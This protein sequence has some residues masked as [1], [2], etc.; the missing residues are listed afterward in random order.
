MGVRDMMNGVNR[1]I[2]VIIDSEINLSAA[3]QVLGYADV[4]NLIADSLVSACKSQTELDKLKECLQAKE[5]AANLEIKAME[6][7][8]LNFA[9]NPTANTKSSRWQAQIAKWKEHVKN[10]VKNRFDLRNIISNSAQGV[11]DVTQITSF[12]DTEQLRRVILS[13]RGSFL[14]II[15]VMMLV[16]GLFGPVLLA[17]LM[18]SIGTK[19]L[20]TWL[21]T[22]LTLG[23]CKICF[24]RI[25][26]LSSLAIAY[27]EPDN[28]TIKACIYRTQRSAVNYLLDLKFYPNIFKSCVFSY[29]QANQYEKKY[30]AKYLLRYTVIIF[31]F[32]F[33]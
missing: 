31:Y 3:R 29:K 9:E 4:S 21:T 14:Y 5:L 10:N 11:T 32:H 17:L 22:F 27:S 6:G 33:F 19:P 20:L 30:L 23:F 2:N 26:G 1:S 8:L 16:T 12:D 7:K 13:F 18:L 24:T 25:S 15:E 28:I